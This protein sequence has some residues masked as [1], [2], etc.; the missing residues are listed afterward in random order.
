MDE[1]LK[2]YL[3]VSRRSYKPGTT[4]MLAANDDDDEDDDVLLSIARST[5]LEDKSII[6]VSK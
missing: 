3:R 1:H 5:Y 2:N 6:T 4:L